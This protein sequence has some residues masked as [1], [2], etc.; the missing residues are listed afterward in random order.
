M[1]CEGALSASL[2][3]ENISALKQ[4]DLNASSLTSNS[5]V[6][7]SHDVSSLS[8]LTGAQTPPSAVNSIDWRWLGKSL[9]CLYQALQLGSRNKRDQAPPVLTLAEIL[10]AGGR[11]FQK[12]H[13]HCRTPP[14]WV[15]QQKHDLP[16]PAQLHHRVGLGTTVKVLEWTSQSPNISG[17]TWKCPS[18]LTGPER[19]WREETQIFVDIP[20]DPDN[21]SKPAYKSW[22]DRPWGRTLIHPCDLWGLHVFLSY[23]KCE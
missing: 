13:H 14:I 10:C 11:K 8:C 9:I 17:N 16:S 19:I 1:Y 2:W 7:V 12:V 15:P 21:P 22:G 3:D 5:Q 6:L 4:Q 18:N 23:Y 20:L